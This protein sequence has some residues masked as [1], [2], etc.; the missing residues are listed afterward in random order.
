MRYRER[1]IGGIFEMKVILKDAVK[2][3]GDMGE[4]VNIA[5]GYGRNYLI[6]MGLAITATDSNIISINNEKNQKSRKTVRLKKEAEELAT[7]I[8][9]ATCRITG[10]VGEGDRLFGSVTS[11][12]IADQLKKE[13]LDIDK[14]KIE[15]NTPIKNLGIFNIP[16][17]LHS[18]VTATI[19][20]EVVKE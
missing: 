14:K 19:K 10:K 9:G 17:K 20:V 2:G 6:P 11:Q 3:L 8:N 12:D 7:R 5:N 1:F 18:G 4:I 16:I 13:G 15:I